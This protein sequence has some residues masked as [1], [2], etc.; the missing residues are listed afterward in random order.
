MGEEASEG[1]GA[2]EGLFLDWLVMGD[3]Y[4]T[5]AMVQKQE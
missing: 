5:S 1:E 4:M 3:A 2:G